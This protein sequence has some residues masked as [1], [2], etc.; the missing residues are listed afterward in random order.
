MIG[1][2]YSSVI[3]MGVLSIA[4]IV[5]SGCR[6]RG[7]PSNGTEGSRQQQAAKSTAPHKKSEEKPV[8][9]SN[10]YI[11]KE[12]GD[13]LGWDLQVSKEQEGYRVIL[14]CGAGVPEGP[15]RGH[16]ESLHGVQTFTPKNDGCGS[17]LKVEFVPRG[18]YLTTGEGERE[19]V[20]RHIN[21][22]KQERYE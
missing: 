19:L 20:L 5:L 14:F 18:V 10:M 7:S 15:I 12:E 2:R 4:V 22:I 13:F 11:E 16:L 17:P 9:Y 1:R 3:A 21:F 8:G 6:H